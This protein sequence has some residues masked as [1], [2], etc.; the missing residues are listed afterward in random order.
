LFF[1]TNFSYCLSKQEIHYISVI[2]YLA[3]FYL[4]LYNL[5][6]VGDKEISVKGHTIISLPDNTPFVPNSKYYLFRIPE[7]EELQNTGLYSKYPRL[8]IYDL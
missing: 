4:L 1:Y 8:S 5:I 2:K 3:L 7:K 6:M